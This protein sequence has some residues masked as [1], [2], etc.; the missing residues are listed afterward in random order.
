MEKIVKWYVEDRTKWVSGIINMPEYYATHI[1]EDPSIIKKGIVEYGD[2]N[3]ERAIK[4]GDL[5]REEVDRVL[6]DPEV[7][8]IFVESVFQGLKE[9]FPLVEKE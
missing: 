8:K 7:F 9:N 2:F 1:A 6:K 4:N 3:L 5:S